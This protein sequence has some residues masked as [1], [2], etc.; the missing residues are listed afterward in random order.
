MLGDVV[1]LYLSVLE[2]YYEFL[3]STLSHALSPLAVS[4]PIAMLLVFACLIIGSHR[5]L[6]WPLLLVAIVHVAVEVIF[7]TKISGPFISP[8][9]LL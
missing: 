2:T 9:I 1:Y 7:A 6:R 5:V 4:Y 8:Q 3:S